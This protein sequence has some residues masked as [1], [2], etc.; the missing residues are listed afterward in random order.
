[1]KR[2]KSGCGVFRIAAMAAVLGLAGFT[3]GGCNDAQ[4][5][6]LFGAGAGA[7]LGQAIGHNT[8][9]TLIGAGAG[10]LTG[11][12]IGNE[13]DKSRSG[14]AYYYGGGGAYNGCCE[15]RYYEVRSYPPPRHDHCNYDY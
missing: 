15:T 2:L 4:A 1:M 5:G 11:Y 7:L 6:S 12:I 3:L 10:A 8:T 14:G 13:A 9:G